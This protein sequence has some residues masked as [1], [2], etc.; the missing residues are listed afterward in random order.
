MQKKILGF[1]GLISCGKGTAASYLKEKYQAET[2][3]FSTMLRDVLDRLYLEHTRENMSG[4][5]TVLREFFGQDLMAEVMAK[6]VENS[7][8][9]LVVVEGIRRMEDIEYLK[10]L[11]N[12]KLVS[13]E[14][15]M[16]NRYQRLLERGE[17][18]DDQTKTWEQFQAD[19]NLE[20]ELT[21]PPAMKVADVVVNNDGS[22]E[23]FQK[24]LDQL[25]K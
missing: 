16:E 18:P 11:P 3:R 2:F 15:T 1:T 6:D 4:I 23:E 5:S 20:T 22:L 10:K 13:I 17:N 25:L 24:Q 12:F 9:E 19:H 14:A 21:I 8:A 7:Q